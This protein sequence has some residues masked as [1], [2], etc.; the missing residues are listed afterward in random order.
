MS[1]QMISGLMGAYRKGDKRAAGEL[2]EILYPELRR[3]AKSRMRNEKTGHSWQPTLLVN[4]LYLELIKIKALPGPESGADDEKAAFMGLAAHLMRRLLIHHSRPLW[5]HAVKAETGEA[6]SH[7]P[8][9]ESLMGIEAVLSR[10]HT[11]RPRLRSI[12]ELKVFEGMTLE[13][14][15]ERL[16]CSSATVTREWQFARHWLQQELGLPNSGG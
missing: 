4:E 5:A 10:L 6:A 14:V 1:L 13:E 12:V 11:I 3:I 8:G 2:V 7:E 15:A 16:A 9:M